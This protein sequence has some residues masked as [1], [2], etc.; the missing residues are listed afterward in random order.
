VRARTWKDEAFRQAFLVNPKAVLERDYAQW[1]PEGK[2]PSELSIKVIEE[3][4]Q[5]ICFV[6]PPRFSGDQLPEMEDLDEEE[7]E[8]VSG[9]ISTARCSVLPTACAIPSVCNR[10]R[11]AGGVLGKW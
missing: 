6:L 5:A 9:G 2:L 8:V 7:L 4:A 3:E 10:C 1:F 11:V